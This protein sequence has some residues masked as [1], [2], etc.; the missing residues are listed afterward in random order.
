MTPMPGFQRSNFLR[1]VERYPMVVLPDGGKSEYLNWQVSGRLNK[2]RYED[3]LMQDIPAHRMCQ[4][5]V[6][7]GR[8]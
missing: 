5:N 2:H 7:D 3:L 8:W 6:S 4:F 1:R